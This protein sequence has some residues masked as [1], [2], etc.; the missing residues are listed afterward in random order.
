MDQKRGVFAKA[1]R[2]AP[3]LDRAVRTAL[4]RILSSKTF[5]RSLR[6]RRFLRYTVEQVLEGKSDQLKE[7]AVAV[8]VFDRA[9]TFDARLDPIVR[10][11][12]RRLRDKLRQ[13]YQTEGRFDDVEIEYP[14]GSYVPRW[15]KRK[16]G[17]PGRE[18]HGSPCSEE[19][20][21][22]VLPFANLSADSE[23]E[24]FS[25]GLTEQIIH[26]LTKLDGL[27]VV[28]WQSAFQLKGK[29]CDLRTI[30]EQLHVGAVLG[31]SVRR[32]GN[33]V[34]I[35]A[36]LV[37]IEDGR[38]LWS[39]T[40]ERQMRDVLG[41]QDEIS[42]AIAGTLRL[43]LV[44]EAAVTQARRRDHNP[45]AYQLYLR[46]R[47]HWNK[48]S[49]EELRKS[50]QHYE[51]AIA[52]DPEFPLGYA[53]LADAYSLLG[54]YGLTAPVDIMPKAKEAA[55]KALSLDPTLA[56][57]HTSLAFIKSLFEW[58]WEEAEEHYRKSIAL[59]PGYVT[60]HHWYGLD[61]LALHGRLE[62]AEAEVRI[63]AQLDP[64]SP[65][66][67]EGV[68]YMLLLSR[69][70]EEAIEQS[71]RVLEL[72]P[73]FYKAF[74]GMGRAYSLMGRYSEAIGLLEKGRL[75]AG[76]MPS[77]LGALGQTYALAGRE[78][79]ARRLLAQLQALSER[80]FI[81]STCFAI[82]HLGLGEKSRALDWLEL[83]CERH[84]L[85]VTSINSHP[86]YDSLRNEPRFSAL[87]QRIG[88]T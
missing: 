10:V 6:M 65:I 20:S 66:I 14:V 82:V 4:E 44:G 84:E 57:A 25:D 69:R 88:F 77:I 19:K 18:L 24:Y 39:E 27:R 41:I 81:P 59:N 23:N 72:D 83:G 78:Q 30:G 21:L 47:F 15:R 86:L 56:E 71:R 63:A 34:R 8:E 46:G 29:P 55:E 11:E 85:T 7:Y 33:R 51:R 67:N 62:D 60:A 54:D 36:Q 80:R 32:S 3:A 79:G 1:R 5:S 87:L 2:L 37:L 53:G 48:R 64:L 74:T 40:Y 49:P 68:S 28:A 17:P 50:I 38:Y 58:R 22:V 9:P 31:G 45:V 35:A 75:L 43:K 13:Y 12:A 70:Y 42:R 73:Q 16:S 52:V 61:F 76:D 26:E